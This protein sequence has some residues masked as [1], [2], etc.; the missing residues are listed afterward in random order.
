MGCRYGDV[1][2]RVEVSRLSAR[3]IYSPSNRR[4]R[5]RGEAVVAPASTLRAPAY[6][7]VSDPPAGPRVK[8]KSL[9]AA[10]QPCRDRSGRE[11]G[12]FVPS[13]LIT[14]M[15]DDDLPA[16]WRLWN[17]EP[18]GRVILTY[19]PEVFDGDAFPAA[20]L[21]TIYITNGSRKARPGAGQY[22]TDEW[23]VTLFMEP[24]VEVQSTTYDDRDV[25]IDAAHDLAET[26]ATGEIDYRGAYQVPRETYFEK[27]DELTGRETSASEPDEFDEP[28][29]T[30]VTGDGDDD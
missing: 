13:R 18:S 6:P 14:G 22:V 1:I 4:N 16:G 24:E 27:L 19:R 9:S 21:P 23:H 10:W 5:F 7:K 20:C 8:G 17:A 30:D 2:H 25:A 29:D 12:S 28:D 11:R 3:F 26:F 15:D